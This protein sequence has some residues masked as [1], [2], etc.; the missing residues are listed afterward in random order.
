MDKGSDIFSGLEELGFKNIKDVNIY[1]IKETKKNNDNI[2]KKEIETTDES[3]Y[4]YDRKVTCPVCSNEFTARTVKT[5]AY[6]IKEKKSDFYIEYSLINPYF[7]DVWLCNVCGYASMKADFLK[8]K[9][10]EKESIV[11]KITPNWKGKKYPDIYDINIAIE[12][13]KLSLLNLS[14]INSKS[15][16]K[17]INCLKLAWLY[18]ELGD[19]NN[20]LLFRE[21]ALIGLKDAYL[22]EGFPIYGMDKFKILYLIGELDRQLGHYEES[23]RYLGE[24]ITSPGIDRKLK[25]L[26]VD[27]KNLIKETLENMKSTDKSTIKNTSA[28]KVNI[29]EKQGLFSKFFMQK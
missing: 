20:E 23:L 9:S 6:R 10:Y 4:L 21:Q 13:Y 16:K 5:N 29:N 14:I 26:A 7:Y 11:K 22:N 2:Q 8:I 1:E 15:S 25:D 12:R 28:D 19:E 18:R 27:Q 17:A 24:V 3:S